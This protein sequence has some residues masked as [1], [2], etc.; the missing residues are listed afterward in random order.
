MGVY[1]YIG[2][3]G[4]GK[5]FL[6]VTHARARGRFA[7]LDYG[8]SRSFLDWRPRVNDSSSLLASLRKGFCPVWTPQEPDDVGELCETLRTQKLSVSLLHDEAWYVWSAHHTTKGV[9][10]WL[11]TT[12]H[13]GGD[14]YYTSQRYGDLSGDAHAVT[15]ILH[16]FRCTAPRDLQR[17]ATERGMDP[18]QVSTLPKFH[19]L[20]V[21]SGFNG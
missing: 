17:L 12:L 6:A 20:P 7:V 1:G 11:R 3:T 9:G 10:A 4:S 14:G 16:V 5:T 8:A 21:R 19:C 18:R 13:H 2:C 15:D